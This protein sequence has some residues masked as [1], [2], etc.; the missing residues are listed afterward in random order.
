[1]CGRQLCQAGG[2]C[3][4]TGVPDVGTSDSLSLGAC[5]LVAE[6]HVGTLQLVPENQT[7]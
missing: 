5:G 4:T 6:G 3:R 2:L 1:V 7:S